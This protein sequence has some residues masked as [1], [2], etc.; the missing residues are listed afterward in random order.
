MKRRAI[1]RLL[2]PRQC[3]QEKS[4]HAQDAPA[5]N[6]DLDLASSLATT[7]EQSASS[8]LADTVTDTVV[9]LSSDSAAMDN[10]PALRENVN[11]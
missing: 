6:E 11:V 9:S 3:Q 1:E 10:A 5:N 7:D 2:V 4:E 8:D